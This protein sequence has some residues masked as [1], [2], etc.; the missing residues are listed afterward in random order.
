MT[1]S[2]MVQLAQ[3]IAARHKLDPALVCAICHHESADWNTWASRYEP[4]FY[5]RYITPMATV[6][7]FGNVVSLDT[8]KRHRATSF[9]LMQVMGQVARERG[10]KGEYL[11]ELCE[12][13]TG[14]EYGCRVLE[15]ALLRAKGDV[16]Q[17]LMNYNG[18]GNP[19]YPDLVLAHI[20]EYANGRGT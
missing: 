13:E 12:P 7:R 19:A 16:R 3:H 10:F 9:G 1:R 20:A 4:A 2:E 18:G 5:E 17:G 6:Q 15:R 11:T 14:I 8:E